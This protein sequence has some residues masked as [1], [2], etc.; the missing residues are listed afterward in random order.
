MIRGAGNLPE[1]NWAFD[2][3]CAARKLHWECVSMYDYTW[4]GFLV[5]S[6]SN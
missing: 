1:S 3:H 6:E 4:T 2:V 5:D